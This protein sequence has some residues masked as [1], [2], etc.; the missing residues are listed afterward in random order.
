MEATAAEAV[1]EAEAVNATEVVTVAAAKSD[2]VEANVTAEAVMEATAA[3]AVSEAEAVNATEVVTVAAAKA[4]EARL[5]DECRRKNIQ[6]RE[7]VTSYV[8]CFSDK[9]LLRTMMSIWKIRGEPEDMS[10]QILKDKLQDIAKKPMNDV[11]PDLESLFDDIEFN[12]REE[13]ATMRATDYMMLPGKVS[14]YTKDAFKKKWHPVDFEWGDLIQIV[15]DISVEQQ[16][17]WGA[18]AGKR[19]GTKSPKH[20]K[21]KH[22]H[23]YQNRG[24]DKMSSRDDG[25]QQSRARDQATEAEGAN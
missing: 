4:Y 10:E 17:H 23:D 1:S 6:F 14:E 12:M 11:D 15:V 3:E 5:E 9:Q 8:A 18:G 16:S 19:S 13:D 24:E 25:R 7:H 22:G 2:I 21:S 20:K